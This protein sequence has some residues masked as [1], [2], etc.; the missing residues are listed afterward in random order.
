MGE[1]LTLFSPT[2][3]STTGSLLLGAEGVKLYSLLSDSLP[4]PQ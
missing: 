1:D 3:V 2:A 4:P